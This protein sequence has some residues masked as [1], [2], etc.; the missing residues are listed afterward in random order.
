M[1]LL[2]ELGFLSIAEMEEPGWDPPSYLWGV[3]GAQPFVSEIADSVRQAL[4]PSPAPASA[5]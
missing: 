3:D 5:C 4:A 1:R 2:E